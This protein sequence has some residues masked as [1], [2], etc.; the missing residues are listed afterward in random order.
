MDTER[1]VQTENTRKIIHIYTFKKCFWNIGEKSG[2]LVIKVSQ[3]N[4][5]VIQKSQY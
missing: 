2:N 4:K 1:K 5:Y 3:C